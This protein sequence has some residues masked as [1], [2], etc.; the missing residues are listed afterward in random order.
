MLDSIMKTPTPADSDLPDDFK[1]FDRMKVPTQLM[2]DD[3]EAM[4]SGDVKNAVN[5][6]KSGL[7]D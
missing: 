6:N 3:V 1:G 2:I 7:T 5:L 4:N